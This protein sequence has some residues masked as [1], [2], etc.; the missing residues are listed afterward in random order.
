MGGPENGECAFIKIGERG[1]QNQGNLYPRQPF[2]VDS[3]L[4]LGLD[5]PSRSQG[6]HPGATSTSGHRPVR[7]LLPEFELHKFGG[8]IVN[9]V[10]IHRFPGAGEDVSD[11]DVLI[12][13]YCSNPTFL[14]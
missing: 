11:E 7:R 5:M 3:A 9:S 4:P 2:D 8:S 6:T 10:T 12:L 14:G 1:L 13:R